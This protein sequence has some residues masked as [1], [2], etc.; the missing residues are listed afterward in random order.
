VIWE[1]ATVRLEPGDL[2]L[3]YTDG[4]T[5]AHNQELAAFGETRLLDLLRAN[6]SQ[7]A[8]ATQ[9]VILQALADFTGAAPQFDDVAIMALKRHLPLVT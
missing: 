7:T 5:E 9:Q 8:V 4:V 6:R 3:L 1:Q 2:L